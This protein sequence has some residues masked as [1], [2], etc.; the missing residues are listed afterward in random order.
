MSA[1]PTI[2]R[3]EHDVTER[4]ASLICADPGLLDAEFDA[5]VAAEWPSPPL[6]GR[7]QR[8]TARWRRPNAR[9]TPNHWY[10]VLRARTARLRAA[11]AWR[12][13]RSPPAGDQ[14]PN[15]ETPEQRKGR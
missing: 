4:F 7:A 2:A 14:H 12:W 9:D 8:A 13:P 1:P 11:P 15:P 6:A 5:I 3:V 10:R